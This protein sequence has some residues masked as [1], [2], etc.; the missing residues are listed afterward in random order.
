MSATTEDDVITP[1][2]VI[3]PI[4]RAYY[5]LNVLTEMRDELRANSMTKREMTA[6]SDRIFKAPNL[7]T[8]EKAKV[9]TL[10][11][12]LGRD[13]IREIDKPPRAEDERD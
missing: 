5:V 8:Y 4:N 7:G 12:Q 10:I 9:Y 2:P 11:R 1:V 13:L 3:Q 6:E